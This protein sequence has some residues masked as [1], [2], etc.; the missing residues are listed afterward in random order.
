MMRFIDLGKQIAVDESDPDYPRQFAF[1][2]TIS[3]TFIVAN[4]GSVFDSW[5]EF[6]EQA[7]EELSIE[8]INRLRSLCP[9]WALASNSGTEAVQ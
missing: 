1:Y 6:L 8:A 9:E 4:G 3:D 7:A 5:D 2:N